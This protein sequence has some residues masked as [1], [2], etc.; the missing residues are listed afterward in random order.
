MLEEEVVGETL[1]ICNWDFKNLAIL[2]NFSEALYKMGH[3]LTFFS[4]FI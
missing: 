4:Y 3:M 1:Q 2:A